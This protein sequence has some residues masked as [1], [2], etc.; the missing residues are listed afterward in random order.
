MTR[1]LQALRERTSVLC[2]S[3]IWNSPALGTEG[4]DFLNATVKIET[5]LSAE[6]LKTTLLRQIEHELG[7]RRVSDKFAARTIDLDILIFDDEVQD[8]HI[9]D[10]A[11][12][13]LPLAECNADL[14]EPTTKLSIAQVAAKLKQGSPIERICP[15]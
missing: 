1:A 13:A 4:P 3:S 14:I 11:H 5:E 15:Q 7:R 9:W 10:Y 6:E 8:Q 12:L 2:E